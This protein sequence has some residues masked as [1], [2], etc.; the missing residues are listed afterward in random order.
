MSTIFV[1]PVTGVH[2][3]QCGGLPAV[4]CK[5]RDLRMM[6]YGT[7]RNPLSSH[8]DEFLWQERHGK[9]HSGRSGYTLDL[10]KRHYTQ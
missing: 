8:V 4:G 2:T 6:M 10:L 7:S 9:I 5:R 3:K 1:D